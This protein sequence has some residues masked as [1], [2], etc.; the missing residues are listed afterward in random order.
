MADF[1]PLQGN[2][3]LNA[4]NEINQAKMNAIQTQNA[5]ETIQSKNALNRSQA[6]ADTLRAQL[7]AQGLPSLMAYRNS[8]AGYL[9]SRNLTPQGRSA[10][11]ESRIASGLA[12]TGQPWGQ[13]A[14]PMPQVSGQLPL[15]QEQIAQLQKLFLGS[16]QNQN[17]SQQL[18][19]AQQNALNQNPNINGPNPQDL[20]NQYELTRLK[21]STDTDTRKKNL[22]ATNI[23]K[24][25]DTIDPNII[26]QYSGISGKAKLAQDTMLATRGQAPQDYQEYQS[27]VNTKIPMLTSQI[28]QFYGDS[29]QPSVRE[30]LQALGNTSTWQ[31]PAIALKRY[32]D[33]TKILGT[34][35]QTYRD[36]LKGTDVYKGKN[37]A[38]PNNTKTSSTSKVRKYNP[39]TGKIE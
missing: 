39:A 6:Y 9:P 20:I 14:Q 12:P 7:E 10:L 30:H 1:A 5:P 21:Q 2:P 33:L 11:E 35:M 22:Y 34:E 17:N 3:V 4:L 25:L 15:S 36:A 18:Q 38:S 16:P 24:T 37:Q 31:D 27:L 13:A 8:M 19:Q 32:N 29:I 26:S 28:R 23:E